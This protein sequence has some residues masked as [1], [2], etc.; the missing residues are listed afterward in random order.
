MNV[1]PVSPHPVLPAISSSDEG[2]RVGDAVVDEVDR[3]MGEMPA[4]GDGAQGGDDAVEGADAEAVLRKALPSPY[5]PTI[6]EIR[7]H[8][9]NHLPYRSWCDECVEAFAREWPH[10]HRDNPS[11]RKIP[12]V[13]MD[14]SLIHI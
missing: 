14:L 9:T 11:E 6:S 3:G 7:Q 13:H 4:A 2:G 8:K 10:L 1:R 5:M 12:V